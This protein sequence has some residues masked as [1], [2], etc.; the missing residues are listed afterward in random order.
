VT[1]LRTSCE[2]NDMKIK[3]VADGNC[4]DET[5]R[6]LKHEC[7]KAQDAVRQGFR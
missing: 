2:S 1:P 3:A 4:T 5:P 6:D 7:A